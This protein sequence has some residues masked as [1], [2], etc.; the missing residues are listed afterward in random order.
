MLRDKVRGEILAAIFPATVGAVNVRPAQFVQ[1][2]L[3]AGVTCSV[4]W[5]RLRMAGG[6]SQERELYMEILRSNPD[7]EARII[8][9]VAMT[10]SDLMDAIKERACIRWTEGYSDSL[11][12]AVMCNIMEMEEPPCEWRSENPKT[13]WEAE[14]ETYKA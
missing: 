8:L 7:L 3:D 12:S 10:D 13:D 2:L 4:E 1:K 9:R 5:G 11:Y 6:A 14:I